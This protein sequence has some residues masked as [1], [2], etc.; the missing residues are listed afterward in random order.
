MSKKKYWW[1]D[2]PEIGTYKLCYNESGDYQFYINE[3]A[4]NFVYGWTEEER[5]RRFKGAKFIFGGCAGGVSYSNHLMKAETIEEA[6]KEFEAW[7][8][9]YLSSCVENLKCALASTQEDYEC[10]ILHQFRKADGS[11]GVEQ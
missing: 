3:V 7:Y 4:V 10:W 11:R 1:H 6:K 5:Q 8:E 2:D 9:Q